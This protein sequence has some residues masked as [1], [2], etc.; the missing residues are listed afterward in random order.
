MTTA[1]QAYLR[2]AWTAA[3]GDTS[4]ARGM[5][6][7]AQSRDLMTEAWRTTGEAMNRAMQS[8]PRPRRA[9]APADQG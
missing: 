9:L 7:D 3:T 1:A 5:I 8:T 6:R 2:G 4:L